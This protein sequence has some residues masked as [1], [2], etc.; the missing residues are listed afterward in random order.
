M[1][2]EFT[3]LGKGAKEEWKYGVKERIGDGSSR[4]EKRKP[5]GE[6]KIKGTR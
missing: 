4:K 2:E 1:K 5:S 3:V 6:I